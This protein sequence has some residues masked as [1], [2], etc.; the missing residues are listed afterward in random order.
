MKC[1]SKFPQ[2]LDKEFIYNLEFQ[3]LTI[4]LLTNTKGICLANVL[5]IKK[6]QVKLKQT[7]IAEIRVYCAEPPN[8]EEIPLY[9]F[10]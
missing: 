4:T 8:L 3:N 2:L 7:W 1:P 5:Q 10:S 6:H 9:F